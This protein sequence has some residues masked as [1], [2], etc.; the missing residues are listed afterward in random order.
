M[1]IEEQKTLL[2]DAL[3]KMIDGD[4]VYLD[5]PGHFNIGDQLIYNGAMAILDKVVPYKCKYRSVVENLKVE[6][7]HDQDIILLHGGGNWGDGFYTQFRNK[8]VA[9]FP[10]NKIIIMPQTIRYFSADIEE[11]ARLYASHSNL[12]LCARDKRSFDLL[13]EHF[14]ANNIY[15]LPDSAVGLWGSLPQWTK[16]SQK[17]SLFLKR[18]DGEA[19]LERWEVNNADVKDWDAILEDLNFSRV[20]CPYR[21][22]RKIKKVTRGAL[23]KNTANRYLVSVIEP[24]IMKNIPRYFLKYDKL[25]TTRLHGLLLAKLLEM[26]VEY[27]DTRY[28]KISGYCETWF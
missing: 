18:M 9:E 3:S 27:Q 22:I 5:I 4:Y 16:D 17:R 21:G 28:G 6:R 2:E 25:Y 20:L 23:L 15:L 11:D 10:N 1:R 14:S 19:A 8:I 26:P 13:R 24:F 12:H 7:I